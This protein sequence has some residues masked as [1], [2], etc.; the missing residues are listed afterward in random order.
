MAK[1]MGNQCGLNL[2]PEAA[3][4]LYLVKSRGL[5]KAKHVDIGSVQTRETLYEEPGPPKTCHF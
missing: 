5:G 3:S 4:T 2:H 1:D